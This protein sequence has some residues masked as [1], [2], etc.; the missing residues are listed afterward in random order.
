M[1]NKVLIITKDDLRQWC[2]VSENASDEQINICIEQAQNQLKSL[3]CRDY[4]D[5]FLAGFED[6]SLTGQDLA[7][8]AYVKPYL[9]WLAYSKYTVVGS[10]DNTKSGF[11]ELLS[12]NSQPVTES[13]LNA[14]RK[15]AEEQVMYYERDMMYFIKSNINDFPVY[16][17]SNCYTGKKNKLTFKITGA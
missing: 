15:N 10:Q 9:S 4:Y 16:K 8:L 1:Q 14:I 2:N 7:L 11:R 5:D 6:D 13:R 17:A 12:D 3:F